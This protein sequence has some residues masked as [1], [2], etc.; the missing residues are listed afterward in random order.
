MVEPKEFFNHHSD[1]AVCDGFMGNIFLK[2][3]EGSVE[4]LS[5]IL[6]KE[7]KKKPYQ[8]IGFFASLST[9]S[10]CQKGDEC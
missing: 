10:K 4:Q 2:T 7:M 6:K 9:V 1:V 8:N 3:A 5:G